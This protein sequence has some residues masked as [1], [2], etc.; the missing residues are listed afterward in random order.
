M[1]HIFTSEYSQLSSVS[2]LPLVVPNRGMSGIELTDSVYQIRLA[3]PEPDSEADLFFDAETEPTLT[4]SRSWDTQTTNSSSLQDGAIN[5]QFVFSIDSFLVDLLDEY[6]QEHV[7]TIG[8]ERL[9]A[10]YKVKKHS[11]QLLGYMKTILVV[12]RPDLEE[13]ALPVL[14]SGRADEPAIEIDYNEAE[15]MDII[16]TDIHISAAKIKNRS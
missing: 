11:S 10:E 9:Q 8:F 5:L 1:N 2:D 3:V 4:E 7:L 12:F 6:K 16:E 15:L 14:S 13:N